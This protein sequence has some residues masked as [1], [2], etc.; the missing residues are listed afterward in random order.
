M[1]YT[2]PANE[3]K[4]IVE[5]AA[6]IIRLSVYDCDTYPSSTVLTQEDGLVPDTLN[7]L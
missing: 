2:D 7:V 5:T 4:R 6:S 3:R 1:N